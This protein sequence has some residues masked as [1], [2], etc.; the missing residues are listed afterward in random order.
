MDHNEDSNGYIFCVKR[1]HVI[2]ASRTTEPGW[3]ANDARGLARVKGITNNAEGDTEEG[4][5]VYIESTKDIPGRNRDTGGLWKRVLGC[6][7]I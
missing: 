3:Y 1:N 4:L 5:K 2:D 7:K 6:D